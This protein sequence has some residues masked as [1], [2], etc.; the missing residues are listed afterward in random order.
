MATHLP[1]C[2]VGYSLM[3]FFSRS[4]LALAVSA[5]SVSLVQAE[6]VNPPSAT[7]P[8]E[9]SQVESSGEEVIALDAFTVYGEP[10]KTD[11]ATKLGL[12]VYETPQVV[13][14]LSR[15]QID[16]Y[17]LNEINT[18]LD[19]VPGVT[20]ERVETDR[21]Y[22][23][24]RGFDIVNFQFDGVGVPFSYGLSQG[25]EDSAMYEKVEVVKGATGIITGLSNPSATI[26][27]V[28]K[29]PTATPQGYV[30]TS[31]GTWNN[32]RLE[33]DL[34]GPLAGDWLRGRVVLAKQ[35]NDS[36]LDR[37]S[38]DTNVFYGVLEA[39]VDDQTTATLG[40]SL[41][42]GHTDGMTSGALPLF[43]ADGGRTHYDESTSTAPDW[44]YQDV[45][46]S[47]TFA[48]LEHRLNDDWSIKGIYTHQVQDKDWE[49]LYLDGAPD[50]SGAGMTGQASHYDAR[51]RQDI[52]D[53][54]LKGHFDAWGQEHD[55]VAGYNYADIKLTGRSIYSSAWSYDPIGADWAR[56]NTPKPA[57]DVYDPATQS[58]DIDQTQKSFYF[59][60]RLRATDNLSFLLGARTV[61]VEQSGVSYGASQKASVDKT[62]PYYGITYEL[63]PGTMLYGSYSEVVQPQTWVKA[64]LTPLG[65]VEGDSREFGIKQELFDGDAVLT[66]SRFKSHQENFGEYVTRDTTTGLNIYQGVEYNSEGYE[67]ELAGDLTDRLNVSAGYTS[68]HIED[69]NGNRARAFIP[70]R[71]LKLATA[72]RVPGVDGL[73]VGG[74]LRWQNEISYNDTKVQGDYALLDLFVSY[75]PTANLTLALNAYNVTDKSYRE[76]PQWGQANYGAPRHILGT[77]TYEF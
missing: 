60:T 71:Q 7:D 28:R 1:T 66:L 16:D 34:S 9:G 2:A 8:D 63:L 58:T 29:R 30:K 20:V 36:Y 64:D 24:A 31:V 10:A 3:K 21:T 43:Y 56:G 44:A 41:N 53:L 67:L 26:N 25:H 37:Y 39:D 55:V 12:L 75:Q 42:D 11:S 6:S 59:S 5:A 74:G 45:K 77:L 27:Y 50:R 47:R 52:V 70:T 15:D 51:D 23:T 49:V 19:Y 65:A 13:S 32:R 38:N 62:V 22:Y 40:Y 14:V 54:Y 72:Y 61:D 76:S 68:V 48:E 4:I 35:K 18:M 33:T 73:R 69:D 46:Q 17:K 57:F